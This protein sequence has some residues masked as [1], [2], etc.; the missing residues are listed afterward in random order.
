MRL[1]ASER[2]LMRLHERLGLL[3]RPGLEVENVHGRRRVIAS[4]RAGRLSWKRPRVGYEP[5]NGEHTSGSGSIAAFVAW[6]CGEPYH[7]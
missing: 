2:P 3:L 1:S 6:A 7:P 5:Q 4:V